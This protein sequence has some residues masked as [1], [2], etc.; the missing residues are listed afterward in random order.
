MERT[1]LL[2]TLK[3]H[4]IDRPVLPELPPEPKIEPPPSAA[5]DKLDR[6]SRNCSELKRTL[7]E[8]QGQ[9]NALTIEKT[10]SDELA[11]SSSS[12]NSNKKNK[13]KK[14]KQKSCPTKEKNQIVDSEEKSA[15][16]SPMSELKKELLADKNDS[17]QSNDSTEHKSTETVCNA[18]VEPLT[19]SED[20]QEEST[21]LTVSSEDMN[22]SE[23]TVESPAITSSS[24][25][26]E[27]SSA[28]T[29]LTETNLS[30]VVAELPAISVT[31]SAKTTE[32]TTTTN[33]GNIEN[34]IEHGNQCL[35]LSN[36]ATSDLN[37]KLEID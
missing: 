10:K 32:S 33:Q 36:Q 2:D 30:E 18:N 37:E 22:S 7:A 19:T 31:N 11:P 3:Q 4:N 9:M 27:D 17:N 13:N 6:M 1:I 29:N 5:D 26:I 25:A 35:L 34:D 16:L 8:L 14:S 24:E 21:H 20:H 12:S 23:V 15:S 28:I